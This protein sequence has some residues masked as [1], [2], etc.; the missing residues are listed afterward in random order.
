MVSVRGQ[1]RE[2]FIERL[3]EQYLKERKF[4]SM[5]MEQGSRQKTQISRVLTCNRSSRNKKQ[6]TMTG[7]EGGKRDRKH[8]L[9][10]K[11]MRSHMS[12]CWHFSFYSE[13]HG[14]LWQKFEGHV[15][16]GLLGGEEKQ[17]LIAARAVKNLLPQL[18]IE[19]RE[20][21]SSEGS[22]RDHWRDS[23][24]LDASLRRLDRLFLIRW[25]R[26]LGGRKESQM[27]YLSLNT[28]KV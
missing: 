22:S 10:G 14:N 13:G 23:P 28:Y 2:C 3:F 12:P 18:K 24:I 19:V 26:Y 21:G 16:F 4:L 9:R 20:G 7:A 1:I 27:V 15:L 17:R 11:G 25:V 5:W 6:A 8:I